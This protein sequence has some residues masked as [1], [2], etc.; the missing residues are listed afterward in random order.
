MRRCV[1]ALLLMGVL[2]GG[3]QARPVRPV[4]QQQ[5]KPTLVV[6]LLR[7]VISPILVAGVKDLVACAIKSAI[8]AV[9]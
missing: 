5:P 6:R 7:N 1:A 3:A 8:A 2:G 9:L 4:P